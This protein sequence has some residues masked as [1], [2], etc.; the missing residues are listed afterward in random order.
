MGQSI[1][2]ELEEYLPKRMPFSKFYKISEWTVYEKNKNYEYWIGK[3]FCKIPLEFYPDYEKGYIYGY[4]HTPIP[5]KYNLCEEVGS[6]E[7]EEYIL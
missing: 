4:R 7:L 6:Y 3:R 5:I 2:Y 1:S